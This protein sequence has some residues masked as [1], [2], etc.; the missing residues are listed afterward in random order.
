MDLVDPQIEPWRWQIEERKKQV[1]KVLTVS[2]VGVLLALG[3]AHLQAQTNTFQTNVFQIININLFGYAQSGGTSNSSSMAAVRIAN[4]QVIKAL[5]TALGTNFTG[6][7]VL[8][9]LNP[10]GA[11][12]SS[13]VV[14]DVRGKSAFDTD[15]SSFFDERTIAA[16]S[17]GNPA[18]NG[19]QVSIEEFILRNISPGPTFDVQGW[20]TTTLGNDSMVANV[21]GTGTDTSGNAAVVHGTITV[22]AQRTERV[23]VR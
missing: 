12:T 23:R 7:A 3:T 10:V 9:V 19:L 22:G 17:R 15:V 20:T 1:K 13:I 11:S 6:R 18:G 4:P 5:G 21:A 16:V 2:A 8:L 14:R